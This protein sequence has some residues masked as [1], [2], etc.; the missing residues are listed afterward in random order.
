MALV[1]T[2][3]IHTRPDQSHFF[4]W[5]ITKVKFE[6]AL[7]ISKYKTSWFPIHQWAKDH[8]LAGRSIKMI[9]TLFLV[10][11]NIFLKKLAAPLF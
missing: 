10:S 11:S 4:F 9:Q 5:N 8:C 2:E 6:I 7:N 3:P 1:S